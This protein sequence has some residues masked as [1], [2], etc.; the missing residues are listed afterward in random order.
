MTTAA[1]EHDQQARATCWCCGEEYDDAELT[2]LGSHPEVGVCSG[3]ARWLAR[4]ARA[5]SGPDEQTLPARLRR[6]VDRARGQVMRAGIH[7][8]PVVGPLLRRL[9]RHLP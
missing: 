6:G 4:R 3:C 2:R 5:G 1:T 7:D 8:W 9:D